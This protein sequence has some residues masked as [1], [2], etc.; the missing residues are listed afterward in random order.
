M[1]LHI[2]EVNPMKK[3]FLSVVC[4]MMFLTGCAASDKGGKIKDITLEQIQE[5]LEKKDNF[6]LI[7]SRESC[8]HCQDLKEMLNKTIKEH[9]TILYKYEM[10][11]TSMDALVKDATLLQQALVEK[12]ASSEY[13]TPHIYYIYEG[14][15]RDSFTGYDESQPSQFWDFIKNNS[16]ENSK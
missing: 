9:A 5:K 13:S 10:D 15:V 14:V 3:I 2:D 8:Q 12:D 4:C 16:L 1:H 7:V 6:V 11:E